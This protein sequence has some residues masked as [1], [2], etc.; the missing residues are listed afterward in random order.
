MSEAGHTQRRVAVSGIAS[1][2]RQR[3]LGAPYSTPP[4]V[5]CVP[6]H[7]HTQTHTPSTHTHTHTHTPLCREDTASQASSVG[8]GLTLRESWG[9]PI[10]GQRSCLFLPA[11]PG[12]KSSPLRPESVYSPVKR[13]LGGATCPGFPG[14]AS[15][16]EPACQYRRQRCRFNPLVGKVP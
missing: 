16:K 8:C 7:T 15:G 1:R 10:T 5:H 11:S 12:S 13:L 9:I 6:V 14:G 3:A 4:H 2:G